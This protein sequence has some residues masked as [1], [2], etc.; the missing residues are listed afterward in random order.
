MPPPLDHDDHFCH[1][2]TYCLL[3][4][5]SFTR[6][7]TASTMTSGRLI[8]TLHRRGSCI[9]LYAHSNPMCCTSRGALRTRPASTSRVPPTP[10]HTRTPKR[11]RCEAIHNPRRGEPH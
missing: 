8:A 11:S 2:H 4:H 7:T 9:N 1:I 10:M 5:P 6:S 3:F